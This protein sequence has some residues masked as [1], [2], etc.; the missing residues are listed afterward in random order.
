MMAVPMLVLKKDVQ[1][2]MIK[3]HGQRRD[4]RGL[5]EMFGDP[6]HFFGSDLRRAHGNKKVALVL[7]LSFVYKFNHTC[8]VIEMK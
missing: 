6:G 5:P 7:L 3:N 2:M 8:I 1:V 4:S